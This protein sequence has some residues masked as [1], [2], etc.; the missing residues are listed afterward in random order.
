MRSAPISGNTTSID[1]I[2]GH[3]LGVMLDGTLVRVTDAIPSGTN[4]L[5]VMASGLGTGQFP[6]AYAA[7]SNGMPRYNNGNATTYN[8]T[9]GLYCASCHTPHGSVDGT[10]TVNNATGAAGPDNIPDNAWGQQFINTTAFAKVQSY[11]L[12]SA[13]PNHTTTPVTTFEGFCEACHDQ[14]V[15]NKTADAS[16]VVHQN[17]PPFCASCHGNPSNDPTSLDFPHTSSNPYLLTS[18]GDGICI[19]C[20]SKGSLP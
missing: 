10:D 3:S 11:F 4:P 13:R 8:G 16:G 15:L 19:G 1:A 12:L 5:V 18:N 9:K 7:G 2:P 17:H 20:H 14:K 6:G